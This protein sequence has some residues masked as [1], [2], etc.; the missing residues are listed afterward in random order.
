M[1]VPRLHLYQHHPAASSELMAEWEKQANAALPHCVAAACAE[2][3]PLHELEE[4]EISLITDEAIAQVHADFLNDP[5]PTDVI[6]FHHGEIL[7]SLD[8]AQREAPHHGETFA[9]ESLLYM[10]HGLLHLG[11]WEDHDPEERAQMHA[12]QGQILDQVYPQ[13]GTKIQRP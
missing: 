12:L 7:V 5:T 9:R 6:T 13:A 11:G 4:I 8:T 2:D 3:A 1:A 10:I